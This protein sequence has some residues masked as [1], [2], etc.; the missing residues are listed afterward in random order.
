MN[1]P[2]VILLAGPTAVGKTNIALD[3]AS[4]LPIEIVNVDSAL[5]Y[6]YL[7]IG[8]AKPS[9]SEMSRIPHHLI[10]IISPLENYSVMQF[11]NDCKS[12]VADIISRGNLPILVGGTMMYYN[13]LINGISLLP[14]ADH[15]LR[16]IIEKEFIKDGSIAMHAKLHALD[17]ITA[18]KINPNDKQRIGR[19]IEVCLLTGKPKSLVEKENHIDGLASNSYLSLAI[20]PSNRELIHERINKRFDMMLENGFIDEVLNLQKIYPDLTSNH[21]SM[22]CVGYRQVWDY[23]SGNTLYS[24]MVEQ[25][26]AAT[27]QL[28]KRQITWLRSMDMLQVDDYNLDH[29]NLYLN[30]YNKIRKFLE[31]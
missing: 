26:K 22:R 7:D 21:N 9:H 12:A 1:N 8:S 31:N 14:E 27:R 3:L 4:K 10:D 29:E 25:G 11:L 23:L 19:A 2:K 17:P 28:A 20:S 24:E 30:I 13:V 6:K 15:E 5:I 18:N 16:S